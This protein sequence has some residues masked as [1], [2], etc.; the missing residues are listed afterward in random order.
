MIKIF[1]DRCEQQI[2]E[3]MTDMKPEPF[4]AR[5]DLHHVGVVGSGAFVS[6]K[7]PGLKVLV[8]VINTNNDSEAHLCWWCIDQMAHNERFVAGPI[9]AQKEESFP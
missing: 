2:V 6:G 1:C 9:A 3:Q 4:R 7:N 5:E 8:R